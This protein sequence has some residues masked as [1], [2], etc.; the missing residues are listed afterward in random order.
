MVGDLVDNYRK[1]TRTVYVANGDMGRVLA[2]DAKSAVVQFLM[3]DRI[4]RV[5]TAKRK[6]KDGDESAD[7][8]TDR[9]EFS[10]AYAITVHKSQ[11]SEWP[12]TIM[13]ID[14]NARAIGSREW[15]YTAISRAGRIG[16]MVGNLRAAQKQAVRVNLER[17]K[18]FLSHLIK[19]G[20]GA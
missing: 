4:V 20:S 14:E 17:R 18:T 12:V 13:V 6:K 5:Q 9:A 1:T 3:P 8:G 7:G 11:G 16:F 15:W 10:L 2:V 19:E